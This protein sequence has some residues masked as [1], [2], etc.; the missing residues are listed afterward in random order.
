[1]AKRCDSRSRLYG[2]LVASRESCVILPAPPFITIRPPSRQSLGNQDIA[3]I[4]SPDADRCQRPAVAILTKGLHRPVIGVQ[5]LAQPG[6]GAIGEGDFFLPAAYRCVGLGRVIAL[7]PKVLAVQPDRVSV[8]YAGL[9][10]RIGLAGPAHGKLRLLGEGGCRQ[11]GGEDK[12]SSDHARQGRGW[13]T[14]ET[15][16]WLGRTTGLVSGKSPL[17]AGALLLV[18]RVYAFYRNVFRPIPHAV[19]TNEHVGVPPENCAKVLVEV[20][21][22]ERNASFQ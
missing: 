17:V 12:D 15:A 22:C 4:G 5:Q 1:M 20:G 13:Q 7:Q 10:G 21:P 14:E 19:N 18:G 9:G 16:R 11:E 3:N 2:P 8:H 6:A